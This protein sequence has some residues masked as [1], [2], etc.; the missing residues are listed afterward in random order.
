LLE[1]AALIA[2]ETLAVEFR[3]LGSEV[4]QGEKHDVDVDGEAM[5]FW[6]RVA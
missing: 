4:A 6:V 3:A 2:G 5:S 1:H